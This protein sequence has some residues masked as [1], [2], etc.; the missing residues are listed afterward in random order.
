MIRDDPL[1]NA[2]ELPVLNYTQTGEEGSPMTIA[3]AWD[4]GIIQSENLFGL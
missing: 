2:V 1:I 4:S 3:F